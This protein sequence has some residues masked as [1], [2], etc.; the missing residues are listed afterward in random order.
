MS[1]PAPPPS[2]S[3]TARVLALLAAFD[4]EHPR[5]T[6]TQLARR[7]G[8]PVPTAHRL[9]RELEEWGALERGADGSYRVGLRVWETGLLAPV[10]SRLREVALPFLLALH[11]ETGETVQLAA[12]DGF[13]AVYVEKLTAEP[14]VPAASRV[15]ARI[16]L[17][18]TGIGKALL[19]HQS[20][21]FVAALLQQP[22][23]RHTERTIVERAALRREL[24]AVRRRG[25]ARSR[26]EFR[27]GSCSVAVPVGDGPEPA[28]AV[29]VVAYEL[30]DDLD[31]CV[32]ALRRAAAGIAARLAAD[33]GA[34]PTLRRP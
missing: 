29:G 27:A 1:A 34:F 11:R 26:A 21:A 10:H 32:P 20:E 8:L 4:V 7:T 19:A 13:E 16:P 33:T 31:R 22:L 23:A 5:L 18:A 2:R 15:G 3:V 9:S 17:H 25:W 24:A 30:R 12:V 28:A 6:V 14:S